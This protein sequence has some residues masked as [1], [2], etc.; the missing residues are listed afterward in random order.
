MTVQRIVVAGASLAGLRAAEG[1]RAA[2]FT[3][4]VVVIGDEPHLPYNRPPLSK[5]ALAGTAT[6]GSLEFRRRKSVDD[7][8]WRLGTAVAQASLVTREVVLADGAVLPFDGLVVATGLRVRRLTLPAPAGGRHAIRTIEDAA[9]LRADLHPGAHVV[10]IGAGFIGCE[11]AATAVGL[12]CDVSIVA[13]EAVPM[14]RPLGLEVG[15]SMRRRHERHGVRMH[16]GRL[17]ARV[18]PSDADPARVGKVVL[19]DGTSLPADVVVEALG[20][21]PNTEWLAA[22]GLEIGLDL[23]DG[24]RTDGWLRAMDVEGATRPDVVAVGDVARFPNALF[25]DVPRRVEHWSIPTD[26]AKRAA[27]AL[28]AGLTGTSLDPAPFAPVPAFWSD[29]Y[30][31]R[32]QS[33]GALGLADTVRV[34]EGD[35]DAEFVAGYEREGVLVGVVGVGLMP[36]LLRLRGEIAALVPAG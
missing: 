6:F 27:P 34:L 19:D 10:V 15:A 28:V 8:V 11:V 30:G 12:G 4:E 3:G 9:A 24:V 5:E 21:V 17:P 36:Q 29:Q 31:A 35:L 33:F 13:P 22:A 14:Q 2:G 32:L 1:V 18:E 20:C 16:L 25:D 7:V 23:A 26:T